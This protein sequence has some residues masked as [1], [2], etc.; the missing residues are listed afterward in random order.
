MTTQT[1]I[2]GI[3]VTVALAVVLVFFILFGNPL[4]GDILSGSVDQMSGGQPTQLIAQDEVVGTGAEARVGDTLSVNYTGKLEDGTVFDTSVGRGPYP[5]VLGAGEVIPGWDQGLA[6]M[7][8]G[9]KRLLIIPASL[10]YG[11]Q[12]RGPIPPNATLIFEVQLV[13]ITPQGQ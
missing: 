9:G 1:L 6:G 13:G 5:F 12:G 2:R 3:A 4:G 11:S 7:K 10:A 8:V